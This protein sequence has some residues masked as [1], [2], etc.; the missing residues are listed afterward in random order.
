M[1][2]KEFSKNCL[3]EALMELLEDQEFNDISIQDI[4]DKAGFSR[5]AYY[6]NFKDKNELLDYYLDS[7]FEGFIKGTKLS[8]RNMGAERFH[9][10]LFAWFGSYKISHLVSLLIERHFYF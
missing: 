5:M 6:R 1:N 10:E 8:F 2:K 3:S 7:V 9:R 4:V